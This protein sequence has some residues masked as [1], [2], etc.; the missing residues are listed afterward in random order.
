[1][2]TFLY[3]IWFKMKYI[4]VSIFSIV[5]LGIS[6]L[7]ESNSVIWDTCRLSD[8]R[9]DTQ[10]IQSMN[11][12]GAG[13]IRG[14][15]II[16]TATPISEQL[17]HENMV[18]IIRD[19]IDLQGAMIVLPK[20]S[21]LKFLGGAIGNGTIVGNNSHIVADSY[22]IFAQSDFRYRG[23]CKNTANQLKENYRKA[24]TLKPHIVIK[25]SWSNIKVRPEW[26][27]LTSNDFRDCSPMISNYIILHKQ[28]CSVRLPKG[29]YN[30][31]SPIEVNN[32][33]LDCGGST[34]ILSR[35]SDLY[36]S[37]IRLNSNEFE[38]DANFFPQKIAP[39]YRLFSLKNA[40][41]S[42][43]IIDGSNQSYGS[44]HAF[45]HNV[46]GIYGLIGIVSQSRISH[47]TLV[48]GPQ[49]AI[50]GIGG[51]VVTLDHCQ[52]L[53]A[54]EHCIYGRPSA[55]CELSMK[56]CRVIGWD[57]NEQFKSVR[58]NSYALKFINKPGV[59]SFLTIE[60][61]IF[62]NSSNSS[63]CLNVGSLRVNINN[64]KFRGSSYSY[65]Y[66]NEGVS[67]IGQSDLH[68]RCCSNAPCLYGTTAASSVHAEYYRS[69]LSACAL[70][71]ASS[72]DRC[73]LNANYSVDYDYR[74]ISGEH[75]LVCRNSKILVEAENKKNFRTII[76][77]V[78]QVSISN[79]SI[80]SKNRGVT[81]YQITFKPDDPNGYG[82]LSVSNLRVKIPILGKSLI[83]ASGFDVR[84]R[85][86]RFSCGR[87]CSVQKKYSIMTNCKSLQLCNVKN[88]ATK[89]LNKV[90]TY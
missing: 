17:V 41:F 70:M 54:S 48:N 73:T 14:Q 79:V 50:L 86:C 45:N 57:N 3:V 31:A 84:L 66:N 82:H 36:D 68:V 44:N 9:L 85:E 59:R 33:Q 72:I 5:F 29:V 24:K 32:V 30:I 23:Y 69:T 47:C 27:G 22:Q 40:A 46:F 38:L 89:D 60:N 78:N 80:I 76:R 65:F 52:V 28:G 16:T 63:V 81:N 1:M 26:L 64:S 13:N 77:G 21:T 61:C 39:V 25:G 62:D 75:S 90:P 56:G 20:N 18:Y 2:I 4:L 51:G 55:D 87:N 53:G 49:C 19:K 71:F 67:S 74:A 15:I 8:V 88:K 43:A 35:L 42:N 34:F 12:M 37:S 7:A 83:D 58:G 6:L 11:E 10:L